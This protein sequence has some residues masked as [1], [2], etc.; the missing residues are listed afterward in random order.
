MSEGNENGE[1]WYVRMGIQARPTGFN[2]ADA[3]N[4]RIP[5]ERAD[6]PAAETA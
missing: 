3:I 1:R 2:R 6:V 5:I 4:I